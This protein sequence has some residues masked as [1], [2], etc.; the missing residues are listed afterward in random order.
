MRAVLLLARLAAAAPKAAPCARFLLLSSQRS[1]STW[2]CQV[3][4]SQP[5]LTCGVRSGKS[6][7]GANSEM[8]MKYS[9]AYPGDGVSWE[10]WEADA[11][12]AFDALR[13]EACSGK[14]GGI[15]FKLMRDQI[16]RLLVPRF[17]DWLAERR[18]AAHVSIAKTFSFDSQRTV[19]A[20]A[21]ASCTSCAR[22]RF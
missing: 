16:P 2:T 19:R 21:S 18:V 3:L 1:G 6:A 9:A 4:D 11:E 7:S 13:R 8:L 20:G 15:G 17:L 10:A 5:G 14:G 12:R 22:R